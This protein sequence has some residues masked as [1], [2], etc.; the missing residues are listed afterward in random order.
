MKRTVPMYQLTNRLHDGR[1]V[2]VSA[3]GIVPTVSAWLAELGTT[4]P[5]VEDL[6]QAVRA[7]DWPKAHELSEVLSVDVTLAA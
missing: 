4:S 1:S 5:I 3:D 2:Q 6:A 7:A